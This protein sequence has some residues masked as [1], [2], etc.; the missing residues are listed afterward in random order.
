MG[1]N[2]NY[3]KFVP[4]WS[5]DNYI[6]AHVAMG[7]LQEE[8]IECW[9]K[10]ENT[11]TIDPLLSNAIGGI[12]L[13][14]AEQDARRAW[15]LLKELERQHK[16]TTPCPKCGSNNIEFVTTPRK[17][18]TWFSFL[19]S[20]FVVNYPLPVNEVYHCFDCSHEFK[21]VAEE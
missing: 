3:I 1:D 16:S 4:I 6:P 8:G 17:A 5:Y 19:F 13:M 15:Q 11:V 12:K 20:F 18:G 10:D 14:T 21:R 2:T 9:L 7:R